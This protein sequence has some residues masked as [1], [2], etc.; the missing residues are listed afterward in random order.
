M[1]FWLL[2]T[3]RLFLFVLFSFFPNIEVKSMSISQSI[4]VCTL[5]ILSY[6]FMSHKFL[7]HYMGGKD[8][9]EIHTIYKNIIGKKATNL[10]QILGQ[11]DSRGSVIKWLGASITLTYCQHNLSRMPCTNIKMSHRQYSVA[12]FSLSGSNQ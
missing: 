9:M 2:T 11:I 6:M 4:E 7:L 5:L 3:P 1:S 12:V 10:N 8:F